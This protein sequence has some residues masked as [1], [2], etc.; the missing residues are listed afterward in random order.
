[1]K[2]PNRLWITALVLGW[3]FDFLFWKHAP[4]ISFAIYVA[5]CLAG[6]F[7]VLGMEGLKPAWKALLLLLPV[8][9]FA[10]MSFIRQEPMSAFLSY[11]FALF[12]MAVLAV[13]WL[14]GRWLSYGLSDYVANGFRLLGSMFAR[15]LGFATE[16]RRQQAESGPRSGWR[17]F[18]AVLR[19]VL[20]ALPILA[21]FASLLSS[22]DLVFAQRLKD[23]IALFRLE[24]LPEYIFRGVYILIGAYLLAGVFLHAAARSKDEKLIGEGKP[25][26]PGFLG[27]TE[28]AVVLGSLVLLFAVFVAIQFRYFFGG[29][30]NIHIEGYT[31]AEYARRGF[32]E[33]VTVAL[34][35]LLLFLGLSRITHRPTSGQR[36]AFSGLGIGLVLLVAVMLVS[37]FQRLLLYEAA[38]GFT[39]LRAYTHVFMIWLG[40]M[41]V[42]TVVLEVLRRERAVAL[43]ALLAALGFAVTLTLLN[44]D[45]FIVRQNVNRAVSGEELDTAYLA[46]LSDDAVPA[47]VSAYQSPDSPSAT[48]EAAG[49]AL[50]CRLHRAAGE[51]RSL[52]WQSFHL[53]RWNAG[54][55]MKGLEAELK[56]YKVDDGDWPTQVTSPGGTKYPCWS[57]YMD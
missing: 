17:C 52:P 55:I 42:A 22:A 11:A 51:E 36:R 6:G 12:L 46:S 40:V 29:Q 9:F 5:L 10:A 7:F 54:R 47:L 28:A 18:W 15:P 33:L 2:Q 4:G 24:K 1:M 27:F 39:R 3:A 32:G 43:A 25:A 14:G 19:G 13:T 48:R 30:A 20:I 8:A 44:V 56:G 45:A 23:F 53:A 26:A 57:G 21:V 16:T 38:Y 35:S 37:A 34:F 31:F 50:A 41:L 49:A